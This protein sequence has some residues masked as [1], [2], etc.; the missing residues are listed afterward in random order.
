MTRG[1]FRR[2]A[3]LNAAEEKPE[4][5]ARLWGAAERLRAK[6]RVPV[7]PADK[8]ERDRGVAKVRAVLQEAAF[9]AAWEAG[10]A[11]NTEQAIEYALSSE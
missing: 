4:Q 2:L 9:A 7:S 1:G 8:E 5:A 6:I 10:R 11:M 3:V